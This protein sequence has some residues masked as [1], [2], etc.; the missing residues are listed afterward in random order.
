MPYLGVTVVD[1]EGLQIIEAYLKAVGHT[2]TSVFVL[3]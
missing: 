3:C 1:D 2:L